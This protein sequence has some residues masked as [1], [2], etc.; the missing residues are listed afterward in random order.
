MFFKD[1]LS[2]E[3]MEM[4]EPQPRHCVEAEIRDPSLRPN[5]LHKTVFKLLEGRQSAL[6]EPSLGRKLNI[7]NKEFSRAPYII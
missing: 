2:G 1:L 6:F 5:W 7:K 4:P 3:K